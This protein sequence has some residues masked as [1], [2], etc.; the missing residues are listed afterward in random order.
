M[1]WKTDLALNSIFTFFFKTKNTESNKSIKLDLNGKQ[2][3]I[4][5][6][7]TLKNEERIKEYLKDNNNSIIELSIDLFYQKLIGSNS[8]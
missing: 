2:V 5:F 4:K 8:K 6:S 3:E 1:E 7:P